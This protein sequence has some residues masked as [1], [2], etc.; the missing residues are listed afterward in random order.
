MKR[1]VWLHDVIWLQIGASA[2]N[3]C[4]DGRVVDVGEGGKM[5]QAEYAATPSSIELLLLVGLGK[6]IAASA[7]ELVGVAVAASSRSCNGSSS[8]SIGKTAG[9]RGSSGSSNDDGLPGSV[10]SQ[11]MLSAMQQLMCVSS[12]GFPLRF[13]FDF[14][15]SHLATTIIL[16]LLHFNCLAAWHYKVSKAAAVAPK[17]AEGAQSSLNTAAEA[18]PSAEAKVADQQQHVPKRLAKLPQQGLP[19]AVVEQ[20]E[21]ISS[22]W[23]SIVLV[24][25]ELPY[26]EAMQKQLLQDLL[27]LGHVLM[28]EVPSPVGCNNPGCVNLRGMSEAEAAAKA[29]GGCKV[30]RYCSQQCQRVHWNVHKSMCQRLQ[31]ELKGPKLMNPS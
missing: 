8:S 28:V 15:V 24:E 31:Q 13:S 27:L 18:A 2:G 26:E 6:V 17:L 14:S 21:K 23:P 20:M 19:A 10:P 7:Q 5:L 1:L 12:M 3:E 29:C 22:S 11:V 16:G 9:P 4:A 30:A 25:M